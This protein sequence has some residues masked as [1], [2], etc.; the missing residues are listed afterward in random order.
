MATSKMP[1]APSETALLSVDGLPKRGPNAKGVN[2][3]HLKVYQWKPGR[4]PTNPSGKNGWSTMRNEARKAL[5]LA[6]PDLLASLIRVAKSGD[7]QALALAL[8]PVL[9]VSIHELG[10]ETRITLA[11]LAAEARKLDTRYRVVEK[12]VK[13]IP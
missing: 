1:R 2:P 5:A 10:D 12:E 9:N 3:E 13:Q 8:R 6:L 4:K 11:Q 7:V